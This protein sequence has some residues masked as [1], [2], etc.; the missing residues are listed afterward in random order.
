MMQECICSQCREHSGQYRDYY[1]CDS[2]GLWGHTVDDFPADRSSLTCNAC[3]GQ[4][5]LDQTLVHFHG[6]IQ[7]L[8]AIGSHYLAEQLRRIID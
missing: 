2:C 5:A 7:Y 4:R 8:D 6:V 1:Q 3:L